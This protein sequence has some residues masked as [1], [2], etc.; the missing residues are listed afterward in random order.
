MY[1]LRFHRGWT[2]LLAVFSKLIQPSEL[3]PHL[4]D[5]R[6][7]VID[8]RFYLTEPEKGE[9][10][11]EIERL[12][13]AVYAH[14]DRDLSGPRS[15]TNG[16]HPMPSVEDMVETFSR[17]GI[18]DEVQVVAYD[19]SQGQ[20]AARL[21]WM[22]RYLGHDAAAVLDGGLQAW[23]AEGF[24]LARGRERREP[25]KFPARPRETMRID[26]ETLER[27]RENR[28]LI[29]AR[30][31]ER[32]RGEVEPFDPVKGRIPG[33]RNH[34]TASSLSADGRFLPPEELRARFQAILEGGTP[35]SVVSYCGSGVTACH[36][37][38]AMEVAG[39]RGAR[40]YPGSWSE[41]CADESRPI[42]R[43]K[44]VV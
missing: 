21:W 2:I 29:D 27:E 1:R 5:P 36:N 33:A 44:P 42:E 37:L 3:A 30:A 14:L 39:L 28:L 18:D 20:I 7:A 16:R 24:P 4:G 32:F 40:L 6:W 13:G 38:L 19:T 11:H 23:K 34:S 8:C 17:L 22:L 9:R 41:W 10:E 26:V 43:G 12:P 31:P 35:E 25:R 15:G